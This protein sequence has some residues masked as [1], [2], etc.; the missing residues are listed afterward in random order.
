MFVD[1]NL[2]GVGKVLERARRD[3]VHSGHPL[4]PAAPLGALDTEWIPAVAAAGLIV[5]TRDRRIRTRAAE[6]EKLK[7]SGLRVFNIAGKQDL[8]TWGYLV[9]LVRRWDDIERLI[10]AHRAGPWFVEVHETRVTEVVV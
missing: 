2:L 7:Q 3:V 9:R 6:L 1:E 4:I 8:T 5:V 10:A